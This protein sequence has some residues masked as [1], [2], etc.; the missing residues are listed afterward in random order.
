MPGNTVNGEL[1]SVDSVR[2]VADAM[3][4]Q[5][6]DLAVHP[7]FRNIGGQVSSQTTWVHNMPPDGIMWRMGTDSLHPQYNLHARDAIEIFLPHGEQMGRFV[8]SRTTGR[9]TLRVDEES[10]SDF[11]EQDVLDATG[12]R[13][14]RGLF[15]WFER[16]ASTA[17]SRAETVDVGITHI[18]PD[19]TAFYLHAISHRLVH[20]DSSATQ[21]DRRVHARLSVLSLN[22][23]AVLDATLIDRPGQ[24][25]PSL[26]DL[27]YGLSDESEN[28]PVIPARALTHFQMHGVKLIDFAT[29]SMQPMNGHLNGHR[30]EI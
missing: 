23:G 13:R 6:F 22:A 12:V 15:D 26:V 4:H 11:Y 19:K 18:F 1:A 7:S 9:P 25:D 28:R 14:V 24:P 3:H 2:Q 20:Q 30:A 29:Q 17:S 16:H 8:L 21:T 5:M 10:G 27:S